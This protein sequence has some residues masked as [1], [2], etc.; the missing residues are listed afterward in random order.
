M[1]QIFN[2]K[3]SSATKCSDLEIGQL[4][5][6]VDTSY[7]GSVIARTFS[8]FVC[9]VG[10]GV[11]TTAFQSVWSSPPSFTP[12]FKIRVLDSDESVELSN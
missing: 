10:N 12:S 5:E 6:I 9:V 7:A 2:K 3:K 1:P 8:G 11:S 4:A